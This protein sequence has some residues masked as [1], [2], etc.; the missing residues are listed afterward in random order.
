MHS[1]Q[2][3]QIRPGADQALFFKEALDLRQCCAVLCLSH[4]KTRRA[5]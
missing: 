4:A 5:N 2:N 1:S 3:R